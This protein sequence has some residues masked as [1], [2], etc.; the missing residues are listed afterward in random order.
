MIDLDESYE[1]IGRVRSIC[2]LPNKNTIY[3]PARMG[4]KHDKVRYRPS[5]VKYD[6]NEI[7]TKFSEEISSNMVNNIVSMLIFISAMHYCKDHSIFY[8]LLIIDM[9]Y[10]VS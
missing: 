9:F 1:V 8:K 7:S 4:K 3:V 6:T 2:L 5:K 10:F